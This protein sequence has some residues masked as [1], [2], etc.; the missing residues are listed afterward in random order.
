MRHSVVANGYARA[1][2]TFVIDQMFYLRPVYRN[3]AL[4]LFLV[5]SWSWF[6]LTQAFWHATENPSEGMHFPISGPAA[7][8]AS[9][10]GFS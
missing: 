2:G 10:G 7:I 1:P 8:E 4:S 6:L 5:I 3:E 9:I